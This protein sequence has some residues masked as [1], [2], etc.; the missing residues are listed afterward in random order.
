[1]DT[2]TSFVLDSTPS[3][4]RRKISAK[5]GAIVYEKSKF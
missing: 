2:E 4:S 5:G 3:S 1:M